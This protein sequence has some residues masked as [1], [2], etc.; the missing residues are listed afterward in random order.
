MM[1]KANLKAQ[2]KAVFRLAIALLLYP[3][4]LA[5]LIWIAWTGRPTIWAVGVLLLV[6]MLDRTWFIILRRFLSRFRQ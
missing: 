3:L 5:V 2:V 1:S 6:L 4:A